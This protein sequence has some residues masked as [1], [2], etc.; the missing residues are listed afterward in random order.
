[1][2]L[3]GSVEDALAAGREDLEAARRE[4]R[5]QDAA[6]ALGS[7]ALIYKSAGDL[8]RA[9]EYARAE[10]RQLHELGNIGRHGPFAKFLAKLE[11]ASGRPERAVRLAAAAEKWTDILGGELPEALIQAGGALEDTRALLTPE[12]HARGVDEG[13]AMTLDEVVAYA[14][15]EPESRVS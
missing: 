3:G 4:G 15:D 9:L 6:E 11:I 10:L 8:P 2:N 5:A 13:R 14:L 1:M 12:E 7:L